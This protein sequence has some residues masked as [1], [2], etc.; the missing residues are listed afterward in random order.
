LMAPGS[1]MAPGQPRP[2]APASPAT[3]APANL[4][5]AG[6]LVLPFSRFLFTLAVYVLDNS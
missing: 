5:R 1:P 4:Q 6:P 3:V 2:S